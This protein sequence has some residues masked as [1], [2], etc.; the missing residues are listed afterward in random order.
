MYRIVIATVLAGVTFAASADYKSA[1]D[2]YNN[3][4]FGSAF[5]EFRELAKAG[6][7]KAQYRLG[8]MY[9]RGEGAPQDYAIALKWL[10]K[11]ADN[12][13]IDAQYF[14]A[15]M[16]EN[17]QGVRRSNPT[18]AFKLYR[19]AAENG[20]AAAQLRIANIYAEGIIV[21]QDMQK[22]FKNYMSA[23]QRNDPAA[24]YEVGRLYEVGIDQAI[25]SRSP[26]I[27][28]CRKSLNEKRF[29]KNDS[30]TAV[31]WYRKSAKQDY[32]PAQYRLGEMYDDGRGVAKNHDKAREWYK[33]AADQGMVEARFKLNR[34]KKSPSEDP[35]RV[36]VDDKTR[37]ADRRQALAGSVDAQIRLAKMYDKGLG[38][39]KDY[40]KAYAWYNIAASQGNAAARAS[41]DA[42]EAILTSSQV[43]RG[44]QLARK[45]SRDIAAQ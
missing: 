12:N 38:V 39:P 15:L 41:R 6:G 32:A 19:K 23:A 36:V 21:P 14:V 31:G 26:S 20:H 4:D 2:A 8:Q 34:H 17:K 40:V 27:H 45:L 44:Q 3:R 7:P 35:D 43:D 42:I 30:E 24:Q 18:T 13:V 10:Q 16:H 9:Y 37:A 11:A 5:K 1:L 22:A 25:C 28:S 33:L 29:S